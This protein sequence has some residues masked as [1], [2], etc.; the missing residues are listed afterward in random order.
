MPCKFQFSE[1]RPGMVWMHPDSIEGPRLDQETS[2]LG[3]KLQVPIA[4]ALDASH[5]LE[6]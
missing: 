3:S 5:T 6:V 4:I 2:S 1:G